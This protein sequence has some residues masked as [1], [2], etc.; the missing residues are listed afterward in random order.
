[1]NMIVFSRWMGA[2]TWWQA[3]ASA[4]EWHSHRLS[5]PINCYSPLPP[6][7]L[8]FMYYSFSIDCNISAALLLFIAVL[9]MLCITTIVLLIVYII[10]NQ[11]FWSLIFFFF[12]FILLLLFVLLWQQVLYAENN[13]HYLFRLNPCY[14][15]F[16][17]DVPYSEIQ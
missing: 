12:P 17:N 14:W 6:L 3:A 13:E 2:L 8:K 9:R 7:S 16:L 5:I 1:M 10:K 4:D 11:A 15:L